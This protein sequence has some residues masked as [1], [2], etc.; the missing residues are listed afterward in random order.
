MSVVNKKNGICSMYKHRTYAVFHIRH[1]CND[2]ETENYGDYIK[3]EY[4]NNVKSWAY[5]HRKYTGLN[6]NMHIEHMHRD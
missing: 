2:T 6:T 3:K 4:S 5:C 1:R